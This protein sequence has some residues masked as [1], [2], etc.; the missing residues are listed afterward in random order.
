MQSPLTESI[1]PTSPT[2]LHGQGDRRGTLAQTWETRRESLLLQLS[3][4]SGIG[5]SDRRLCEWIA[6]KESKLE[7]LPMAGL[8]PTKQSV[9]PILRYHSSPAKLEGQFRS[10]H[11]WPLSGKS[12]L[13]CRIWLRTVKKASPTPLPQSHYSTSVIA[14]STLY[15]NY[16][17]TYPPLQQTTHLLKGWT[18]CYLPSNPE[19][20]GT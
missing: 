3:W 6:T 7:R 13:N 17:F 9:A 1:S 5:P 11:F 20:P 18:I 19:L 16:L 15:C 8:G 12:H 2:Y 14:F 10:P 4:P